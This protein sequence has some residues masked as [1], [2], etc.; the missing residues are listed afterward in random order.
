MLALGSDQLTNSDLASHSQRMFCLFRTMFLRAIRS[1]TPFPQ[2][3]DSHFMITLLHYRNSASQQCHAVAFSQ[4]SLLLLAQVMLL[5]Q[6]D[7]VIQT[8]RVI[9]SRVLPQPNAFAAS[10]LKDVSAERDQRLQSGV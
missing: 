3:D 6:T 10:K 9:P 5:A 1:E 7:N 4:S 8:I 2:R